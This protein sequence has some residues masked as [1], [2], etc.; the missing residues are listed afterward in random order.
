MVWDKKSLCL[1]CAVRGSNVF[2]VSSALVVGY[3]HVAHSRPQHSDM[4][5]SGLFLLHFITSHTQ[6]FDSP[7]VGCHCCHGMARYG[8]GLAAL[9]VVLG[10]K[11]KLL[12]GERL[13][14]FGKVICMPFRPGSLRSNLKIHNNLIIFVRQINHPQL[15]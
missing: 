14:A 8:L 4:F 2:K 3:H 12:P 1:R 13:A 5:F 10:L 9:Q 15:I 7:G 11:N 6:R